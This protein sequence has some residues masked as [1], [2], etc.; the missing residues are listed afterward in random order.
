MN[1]NYVTLATYYNPMLP[2]DFQRAQES[3]IQNA[4]LTDPEMIRE[5]IRLGN[6]LARENHKSA[7]KQTEMVQ[8]QQLKAVNNVIYKLDYGG[9]ITRREWR[10][11]HPP[12]G[13]TLLL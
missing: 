11:L 12:K 1:Q 2:N 6:N 5:S 3:V 7:L 9:R 10:E 4:L 8:R 13:A